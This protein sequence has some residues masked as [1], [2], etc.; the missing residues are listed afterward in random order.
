MPNYSRANRF[1]RAKAAFAKSFKP[2]APLSKPAKE[3][4]RQIVKQLKP[5]S[6]MHNGTPAGGP[7]TVG[8]VPPTMTNVLSFTTG[9]TAGNTDSTRQGDQIYIDRIQLRG[10]LEALSSNDAVRIMVVRQVRTGVTP[11]ALNPVTVMQNAGSGAGGIVSYIQD[12]QPNQILFDHTWTIG[13]AAGMQESRI[14][15]IDLKHYKQPLPVVYLDNTS[16]G[17]IA[18]TVIGDIGLFIQSVNGVAQ[19]TYN[20]N[21][22]FHNK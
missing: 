15:D 8:I 11:T 3:E 21:V 19:F 22:V 5:K 1:A 2:R 16:V 9:I 20:W 10:Y 4:V 18:R 14:I 13:T 6:V 17:S 7:P 12:D